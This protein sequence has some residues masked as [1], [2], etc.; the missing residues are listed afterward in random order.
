MCGIKKCLLLRF[1]IAIVSKSFL[2]V[3]TEAP[4]GADAVMHAL[5][6]TIPYCFLEFLVSVISVVCGADYS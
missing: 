5:F 2:Q 4:V 1:F 6:H 3:A